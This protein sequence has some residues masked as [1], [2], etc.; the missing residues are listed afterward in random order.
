MNMKDVDEHRFVFETLASENIYYTHAIYKYASATM[1]L[2][3]YLIY[4]Y[5]KPKVFKINR[6]LSISFTDRVR[7]WPPYG[8]Q[9]AQ[10][11]YL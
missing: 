1:L 10:S 4:K 3:S 9:L 2:Y 5:Q 8:P 6:V 11:M 7:Y